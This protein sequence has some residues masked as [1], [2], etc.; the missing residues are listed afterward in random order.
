[1]KTVIDRL[2]AR[3]LVLAAPSHAFDVKPDPLDLVHGAGG[4][5]PLH[6]MR[7]NLGAS[8]HYSRED[9]RRV[10]VRGPNAWAMR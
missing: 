5:R 2:E 6:D 10:A 7:V 8:G 9:S 1:V 4:Q 3:S